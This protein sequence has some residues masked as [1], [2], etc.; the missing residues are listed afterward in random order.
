[1]QRDIDSKKHISLRPD[2]TIKENDGT[3]I[4]LDTKWKIPQRFAK[5]SDAYQMNAYSTSIPKVK[6]VVLLYPLVLHS[7]M[8]DDY[9]FIDSEG[10]ERLLEQ[11]IL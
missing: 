2:I 1:M 7:A 8:I 10:K 5:E 3:L 11:L 9:H 6:E 4:I